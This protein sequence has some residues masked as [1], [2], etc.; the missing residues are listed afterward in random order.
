MIDAFLEWMQAMVLH[1][2]AADP[3]LG[4]I[5]LTKG[6]LELRLPREPRM[7]RSRVSAPLSLLTGVFMELDVAATERVYTQSTGPADKVLALL[8][9]EGAPQPTYLELLHATKEAERRARRSR[10]CSWPRTCPIRMI[11]SIPSS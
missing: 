7:L 6:T 5:T 2:P 1:L 4:K 9:S 10:A 8:R 3:K 11:A